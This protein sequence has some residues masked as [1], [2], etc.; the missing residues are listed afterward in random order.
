MVPGRAEAT[1]AHAAGVRRD[2]EERSARSERVAQNGQ[3]VGGIDH[4]LD[5]VAQNDDIVLVPVPQTRFDGPFDHVEVVGSGDARGLDIRL[6]APDLP[7]KVSH[8][9]QVG[10]VPATDIEEEPAGRSRNGAT[11]LVALFPHGRKKPCEP[12]IVAPCATGCTAQRS[13]ISGWNSANA[14]RSASETGFEPPPG[15]TTVHAAPPFEDTIAQRTLACTACHGKEGR[16]APDG[17]YPRIAGKPAAY[18]Y[19]QL[20]NFREGRRHYGLM[21]RLLDPLSEPYM[22]EIAQHF[23]SLDLPYP[24]PQAASVPAEVLERGRRVTIEGETPV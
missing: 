6:Q 16:A 24:P 4:V 18:L 8:R 5:D 20:L 15:S 12:T 2:E 1:M 21:T 17:Y 11:K 3:R 22:L 10:P 13:A 7:A 23:A 19:N 9:P 14:G